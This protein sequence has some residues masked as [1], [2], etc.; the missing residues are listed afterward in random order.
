[1]EI[2]NKQ[3]KYRPKIVIALILIAVAFFL[4][5]VKSCIKEVNTLCQN[6]IDKPVKSDTIISYKYLNKWYP[7]IIKQKAP[8]E[9]TPRDLPI[10]LDTLEIFKKYFTEFCYS[11]TIQDTNLIAVSTIRV[12][13]NK[14]KDYQFN[15]KLLQPLKETIITNNVEKPTKSYLLIGLCTNLDKNKYLGV[16]PEFLFIGKKQHA[17]GIG[18]DL[19]NQSYSLKAYIPLRLK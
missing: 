15:Y 4:I 13:E 19:L 1:M 11:D 6:R 18:Y 3:P 12:F 9:S 7:V 8:I 5:E 17:Y 10:N 14:I 2:I 16:G